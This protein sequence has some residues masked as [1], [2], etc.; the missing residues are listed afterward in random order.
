MSHDG[1][2]VLGGHLLLLT[3]LLLGRYSIL[4]GKGESL[5]F[6]SEGIARICMDTYEYFSSFLLSY[7]LIKLVSNIPSWVPKVTTDLPTNA[8][9]LLITFVSM[10]VVVA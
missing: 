6:G 5:Q 7:L 9:R 8:A 3:L 10:S 4:C 2:Y 1:G